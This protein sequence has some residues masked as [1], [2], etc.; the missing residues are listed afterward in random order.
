MGRSASLTRSGSNWR[1]L[2]CYWPA[3]AVHLASDLL[4][5]VVKHASRL[6]GL[7]SLLEPRSQP[8][9]SVLIREQTPPILAEEA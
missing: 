6:S 2:W 3:I 9:K 4:P 7:G 1:R 8:S 5:L